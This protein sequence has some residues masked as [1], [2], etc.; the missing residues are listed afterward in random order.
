MDFREA[1]WQDC[2]K[3]INVI[4]HRSCSILINDYI[5]DVAGHVA[6]HVAYV[7]AMNRDDKYGD[8]R[9]KH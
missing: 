4:L 5:L 9:L 2:N 6:G 3:Q 7:F 8:W 1:I